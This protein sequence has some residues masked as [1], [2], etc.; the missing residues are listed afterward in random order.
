MY[1]HRDWT[2]ATIGEF[3]Q[4]LDACIRWYNQHRIKLSLGGM[5]PVKYRQLLGIAA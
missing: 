2:Q 5:S 4:A 3:M 1:Y